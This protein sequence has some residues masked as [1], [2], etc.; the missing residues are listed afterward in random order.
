MRIAL[1][2][3]P[4]LLIAS[5]LLL[6]SLA[7]AEPAI[8]LEDAKLEPVGGA[9]ES[10]FGR[11]VAVDGDL[12]VVTANIGSLIIDTGI[13][14]IGAAAY[15][16]ERQANGQWRQ[17]AKLLAD[18][19]PGSSGLFGHSVAV[20]GRV[21]VVGA[22]FA[23]R[24]YVFEDSGAGWNRT[25]IL[26]GPGFGLSVAIENGV[27]ATGSNA[28]HGMRLFRRGSNGW[29]QI[30]TFANGGNAGGSEYRGPQVDIT[31]SHAIHGSPGDNTTDPEL[32]ELVYIY[33]RAPNADWSSATVSAVGPGNINRYVKISGDAALIGG[34][35]Y[36][37]GASGWHAVD[38]DVSRDI[39]GDID[40]SLAVLNGGLVRERTAPGQW[41][42][43][44]GLIAG[45][46]GWLRSVRL[47]GRRAISS[48]DHV[49]AYVHDIP[50]GDLERTPLQ[51]DDFQDGNAGGW[52][53]TSGT[54]S[55]VASSGS[56]VYRQTSTAGNATSLLPAAFG[57]HQTIQAD[58]RPVSFNGSDRWF[59]LAVRYVDANNHYYVSARSSNVIQLKKIVGGN[60]Q[61]LASAPL[62]VVTNRNYRLR[63]EAIGP[64]LR[65]LVD[66]RL[67]LEARDSSLL[68]GQPGL[69]MY[70]TAADYD[71]VLWSANPLR[72]LYQLDF[73]P[74]STQQYSFNSPGWR[75][76]S[77]GSGRVLEYPLTD[78]GAYA[79]AFAQPGPNSS[80]SVTARATAFNGTDR[81]FGLAA[82]YLDSQNYHYLT[83]RN[84][85]TVM[86]RK[87]VNGAIRTLDTASF[88]VGTNTWYRLRLDI[89]GQS[90]RG[91]IDGKLVVEAHDPDL[92]SDD[93]GG[94]AAL[95]LY[96]TAT[97]YDDWLIARP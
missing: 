87:L 91:Y 9:P 59:G 27:I 36:E 3:L 57:T 58:I 33:T 78:G 86:L 29:A 4:T 19:P 69:M 51:Q 61:T 18:A 44:A 66:D 65:L 23:A 97:Q 28:P 49:A 56:L 45:D 54:F 60:V 80:T 76:A 93:A 43:V 35:I 12:A 52:L 67:L 71:N 46:G 5:T 68:Q 70:K 10:G 34:A 73:E 88:S 39:P 82:R 85:N 17:T 14:E 55:V 72:S 41:P 42:G 63:L 92:P 24:V 40:Q 83:V 20:E 15:V 37:R 1:V 62:N 89:I 96:K 25:A 95:M 7:G 74:D 26:E 77:L 48:S 11:A 6:T 32:P 38:G 47:S 94:G 30:A 21:I 90:V 13:E 2:P 75:L 81:W 64:R 16:F 50:S 79:I 31:G 84:S 8:L 22:P 53:Q